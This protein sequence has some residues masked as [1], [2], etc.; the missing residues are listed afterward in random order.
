MGSVFFVDD[1]HQILVLITK[2]LRAIKTQR[3]ENRFAALDIHPFALQAV[4]LP[5]LNVAAVYATVFVN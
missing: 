1:H 2:F 4:V 3:I 5:E